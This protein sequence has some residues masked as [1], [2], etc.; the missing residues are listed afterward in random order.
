MIG[1]DG[2]PRPAPA[3]AP[4]SEAAPSRRDIW[5]HLLLYPGHT[6]PTAAAPVLVAAG[7]AIHDGVL[8]PLPLVLAFVGSWGIHVAGVLLDNHEL[9]RRHP[10]VPE[11]PELL[12]A[13]ADGTLTLRELRSAAYGCLLLGMLA[14]V[15]PVWLGG[16]P[17]IV[18]GC[19][20][21]AAALGYAGGPR[22]YAR[23]GLADPLF[24]LMFGVV[25][26][27]GSYYVQAAAVAGV[28]WTR[29]PLTA[30]VVGLPVGCLVTCV[31]VIDDLRDQHFDAR[32]GWRTSAVRFG[33]R[34][35]RF[36]HAALTAIA[37]LLP[38]WFWSGLG[39]GAAVLLP[40]ATAPLALWIVIAVF[41]RDPSR[42]VPMTPRASLLSML[43]G[44]L[45]GIGLAWS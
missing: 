38:W 21:V 28:P 35:S 24:L 42:L 40:L 15:Y 26:V 5:I 31:L 4:G 10:D 7:L 34:G 18:L 19:V 12:A 3:P 36:E 22:P 17:A 13:L 25:A 8:A 20:G 30:L 37:Y 1:D 43:Y 45:L 41:R 6:L 44:A 23:A 2:T 32:K 39:F 11:H 27:A 9:L 33:R 16:A 29:V 14:G